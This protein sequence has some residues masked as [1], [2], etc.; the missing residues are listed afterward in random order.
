MSFGLPIELPPSHADIVTARSIRRHAT[1]LMERAGKVVTFAADEKPLLVGAVLYWLFSRGSP[2]SRRRIERADHLLACVAVSAALPH[3][4]KLFVNRQRPD[5]K[6]MHGQPRHGIPHSGDPNASFPSGHAMHL[7]A[8]AA[9]LTRT[10]SPPI[11][12]I[13]WISTL[14]LAST[15]LLLLAHYLTDVLS[16]LAMGAAIES[17]I[18][19][20]TRLRRWP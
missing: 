18:A 19:R 1:P 6:L 13:G 4:L 2:G 20:L 7:G 14:A 16:G 11:A 9:G 15:R 8:I 10:A 5:R 17:M 12:A 3:L